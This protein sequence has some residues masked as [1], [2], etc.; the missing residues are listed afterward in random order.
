[1]GR[2]RRTGVHPGGREFVDLDIRRDQTF[3]DLPASGLN[4][5]HCNRVFTGAQETA[6]APGSDDGLTDVGVGSG[7]EYARCVQSS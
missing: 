3:A 1:M 6:Q 2:K 5:F 4:R 7:E